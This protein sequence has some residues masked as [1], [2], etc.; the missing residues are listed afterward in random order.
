MPVDDD[1]VLVKT[2]LSCDVGNWSTRESLIRFPQT[3]FHP[4]VTFSVVSVIWE[5]T[6]TTKSLLLILTCINMFCEPLIPSASSVIQDRMLISTKINMD[7]CATVFTWT[8]QMAS[9]APPMGMLTSRKDYVAGMALIQKGLLES[10]VEIQIVYLNV[11]PS[12]NV[13]KPT[14]NI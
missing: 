4:D 7:H 14:Y 1:V 8:A 3:P 11:W 5:S 9:W 10:L 6:Y 13:W 2:C 12:E